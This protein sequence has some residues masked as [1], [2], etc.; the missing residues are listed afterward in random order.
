M[1]NMI[2][3]NGHR[4]N[5]GSTDDRCVRCMIKYGYYLDIKKVLKEQ[6]NRDDLRE[7]I[8]CKRG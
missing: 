5:E 4:W 2:E 1:R 3:E 7:L 6:H 8:K